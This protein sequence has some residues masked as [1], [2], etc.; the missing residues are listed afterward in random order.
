M[1]LVGWEGTGVGLGDGVLLQEAA[2]MDTQ[3]WLFP[4]GGSFRGK[5]CILAAAGAFGRVLNAHGQADARRT[6]C[7]MLCQCPTAIPECQKLQDNSCDSR[8][9][10]SNLESF[11]HC[12]KCREGEWISPCSAEPSVHTS[13][14]HGYILGLGSSH[15]LIAK[16]TT[17]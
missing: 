11:S 12:K 1:K 2:M 7:C 9:G 16:P 13:R 5:K 6:G 10:L 3:P 17:P 14:A 8:R 4:K 15:A